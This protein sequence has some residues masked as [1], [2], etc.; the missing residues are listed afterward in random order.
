MA[1]ELVT[2]GT[3]D[4][5][6]T[7]WSPTNAGTLEVQS[8]RLRVINAEGGT[9]DAEQL[10]IS[11]FTVG[12][13]YRFKVDAFNGTSGGWRA[14]AG[15]GGSFQID[16]SD[17]SDGSVNMTFVATGTLGAVVL[18]VGSAVNLEYSEFDNVSI[19]EVP[20]G[21]HLRGFF[22]NMGRF[23]LTR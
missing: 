10:N 3:F 5:D 8:Q 17:T 12:R 15:T 21:P 16:E 13:T 6:T 2:N 1:T 4:T 7:G 19:Q 11:G 14:R 23:R 18:S 9:V 20:A 22:A